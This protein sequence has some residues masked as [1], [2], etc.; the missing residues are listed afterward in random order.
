MLAHV[1]VHPLLVTA[2]KD[3]ELL[4]ERF[5]VGVILCALH[6]QCLLL[7]IAVSNKLCHLSYIQKPQS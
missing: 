1:R 3:K 6:R 5:V 7:F 4:R 2:T